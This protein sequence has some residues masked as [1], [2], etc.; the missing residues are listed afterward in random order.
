MIRFC[1][2]DKILLILFMIR[3][4]ISD[5]GNSN[6][7]NQGR[8]RLLKAGCRKSFKIGLIKNNDLVVYGQFN[9]GL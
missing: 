8:I 1:R 9:Y 4:I 6:L 2:L 5:C 3:N 7:R